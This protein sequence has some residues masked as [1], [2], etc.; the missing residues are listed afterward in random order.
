[1]ADAE[2]FSGSLQRPGRPGI[3][4]IRDEFP[5]KFPFD[6]FSFDL[7]SVAD[8]RLILTGYRLMVGITSYGSQISEQVGAGVIEVGS[9]SNGTWIKWSDGT[10]VCRFIGTVYNTTVTPNKYT[11]YGDGHV[12]SVYLGYGLLGYTINYPASFAS[13]TKPNITCQVHAGANGG[14]WWGQANASAYT[15]TSW[16]PGFLWSYSPNDIN[17]D[18]SIYMVAIG[19]WK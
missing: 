5:G 3:Q 1:M 15:N 8:P 13:G 16:N 2:N 12:H 10:M 19:R 9:N 7:P 4:E 18:I 6:A 11:N 14:F 17:T